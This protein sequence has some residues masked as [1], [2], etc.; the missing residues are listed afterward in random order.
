MKTLTP[1]EKTIQFSSRVSEMTD[2]WAFVMEYADK[3]GPHPDVHIHPCYPMGPDGET[4]SEHPVVWEVTV[5]GLI[6]EDQG[7]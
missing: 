7:H 3:V 2:A 6:E 5:S 4:D 1:V